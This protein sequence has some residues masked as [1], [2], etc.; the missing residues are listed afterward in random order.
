MPDNLKSELDVVQSECLPLEHLVSDWGLLQGT[1]Q[2]ISGSENVDLLSSYFQFSLRKMGG[3]G[4][5]S[6]L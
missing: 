4:F 6:G 3:R 5:H 1:E 2:Q